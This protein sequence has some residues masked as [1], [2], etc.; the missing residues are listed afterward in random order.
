[1]GG[2][3]VVPVDDSVT[4]RQTVAHV[5]D[6]VRDAE[7]TPTLYFVYPLSERRD[8]SEGDRAA[9][10]ADELLDRI[11]VWVEEDL[12]DDADD[13][14]V[15]TAVVG[16]AEYLFNPGDYASVLADYAVRQGAET[17]VLDPEYNPLGMAP[18][19]PPLERELESA[20]LTVEMAPVER[21]TR[22]SPLT[23]PAGL[24]QFVVLF[25]STYAFYL[26]VGGTLSAFDL[27]TGAISAGIVASLL[28]RIT[29]RGEVDLSRL[30]GWFGRMALY[31]PYLLWEIVVANVQIA[32]VVLHPRLPIDPKVVEFDAAVWSELPATTLANS[33]TLTPGTLTVDV[34]QRHFTVHSLTPGAREDLLDGALERAVRFVFYGRRGMRIAT[35][36]ERG[37]QTDD[38]SVTETPVDA[39]EGENA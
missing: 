30:G 25:C 37:A 22:R 20:G 6:R 36:R 2:D 23:R 28:W 21:P 35:P 38:E 15:E 3:I 33:I 10:D 39:S 31:V 13:V 32:R 8:G 29:T 24:G 34:T 19:L 9:S 27:A 4:L 5:A 7:G 18:L 11:T 14:R 1:M 26:L 17:V 12:G 16:G